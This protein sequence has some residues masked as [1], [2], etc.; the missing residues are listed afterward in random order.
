M[1][2][3]SQDLVLSKKCKFLITIAWW[4]RLLWKVASSHYVVNPQCSRHIM[5]AHSLMLV[6]RHSPLGCATLW[7]SWEA[8]G[9]LLQTEDNYHKHAHVLSSSFMACFLLNKGW[10][11]K[12]LMFSVRGAGVRRQKHQDRL[13]YLRLHFNAGNKDQRDSICD[14]KAQLL[15]RQWSFIFFIPNKVTWV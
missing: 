15:E 5:A 7:V 9:A 13:L 14:M 6:R 12:A 3:S 4:D 8:W 1:G 10:Q 2:K 11:T